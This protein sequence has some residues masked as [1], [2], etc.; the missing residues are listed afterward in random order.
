MKRIISL[1]VVA[2]L[3]VLALQASQVGGLMEPQAAEAVGPVNVIIDTDIQGD[4]DDVGA[5][6]M[7][8]SL[9]DNGEA[10][11]LGVTVDTSSTWGPQAVDAINTYHGRPDIPIGQYRGPA[12]NPTPPAGN[13]PHALATE[14]PQDL[15]SGANA[16]NATTMLRRLLASQPDDSVVIVAIGFL[17]NLRELMNSGPD[18]YSSLNGMDLIDL[19]VNRLSVM[20]GYYPGGIDGF[21]WWYDKAS[22]ARV[23]N[24]WPGRIIYS[25]LGASIG[26]GTRLATETPATNPSRRAYAIFPGATTPR[27]SWDQVSTLVAVRGLGALFGEVTGSHSYNQTT[28]ENTFVTSP[29]SGHSYLTQSVSDSALATVIEDLMVQAPAGSGGT[30]TDGV[31][32]LDLVHSGKPLEVAGCSNTG[33]IQQATWVNTNCQ[34]WRLSSVG[35]GFYKIESVA[36]GRVIDVWNFS[37]ADGAT[38]VQHPWLDGANQKW[39]FEPVGGGDYRI[40]NLHSGK[41]LDL[42]YAYTTDGV[43]IW[44]YHWLNGANQKFQVTQLGP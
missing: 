8:H 26:T 6:A 33:A 3:A 36:T 28:G 9:A 42:P 44:Q 20:G 11:I 41:V 15:A 31:Y 2:L 27:P 23:I 29:N 32:R 1:G 13:Y 16:E 39:A 22:A 38:V 43:A 12:F 35:G 10:N 21:N 14:F 24:D 19:K 37:T 5:L 7:L 40:V 18:G 4:T 34:K 30:L 17:N 25:G